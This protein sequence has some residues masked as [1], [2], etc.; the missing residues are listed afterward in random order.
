MWFHPGMTLPAEYGRWD[1]NDK[2]LVMREWVLSSLLTLLVG[3]GLFAPSAAG[4]AEIV[5]LDAFIQSLGYD[6]ATLDDLNGPGCGMNGI[7][8]ADEFAV[9]TT[10]L[11]DAGHPHHTAIH[12]AWQTNL[13]R[14]TS[15]LGPALLA[16]DPGLD[17]FLA[18]FAT[19]GSADDWMTIEYQLLFMYEPA[20]RPA[21]SNY[22]LSQ[23]SLLAQDG[24]LDGDGITNRDEY[25]VSDDRADYLLR[26]MDNAQSDAPGIWYVDKDTPAADGAQDGT[27]WATA[28]DTIQEG[29]DAAAAAYASTDDQAE[30]WVAEGT[31]DE[32]RTSDPHAG[33]T[34][35]GSL[36]LTAGVHLYGGFVGNGTGGNETA[37]GQRDWDAHPA[38]IDGSTARDGQPA[39]HVIMGADGATLDGF[40]VT[41][42]NANGASPMD[43]GAGIFNNH[44]SP[45]IANARFSEN[46]GTGDGGAVFNNGGA[47]TITHCTFTGNTTRWGACINSGPD[48]WPHVSYC[49][50]SG[51]TTTSLAGA[52]DSWDNT[53][54]T[55]IECTFTENSAPNGGGA[56]ST[57]DATVRLAGC[58]FLD[59]SSG[60]G[61]AIR[62]W[63]SGSLVN[64]TF[65]NNT[66]WGN[67][68]A[69]YVRGSASLLNCLFAHNAAEF[70]GVL[71][72]Y[73]SSDPIA[74]KNCTLANNAADGD[75]LAGAVS[76]YGSASR[77]VENSILW[78]NTAVAIQ[79]SSA[80]TVSYSDIQH[81]FSGESNL[82]IDPLFLGGPSGTCTGLS[83]DPATL[84]STLTDSGAAFTSGALA[85]AVL[86]LGDAGD[87]KAYLITANDA[88]QLTFWGDGTRSGALTAPVAYTV[89]DYRLDE[90]SLCIDT[91]TAD[92]APEDDLDGKARPQGSGI[93]RGAFEHDP[94]P[95]SDGD[96]I[97]DPVEGTA[98]P[99]GDSLPNYLDPDSDGDG[100]SD[101]TEGW[102]DHDG[103][104]T[105]DALDLDSDEDG[106]PDA[107]EGTGD[108]D[109]DGQPNYLDGDSDDDGWSDLTEH[110]EG[111]DPT[112]PE[113]YPGLPPG[114]SYH[115]NRMW[116]TLQQPWYFFTPAGIAID[117]QDMVYLAVRGDNKVIKFT[118]DGNVVAVWGTEGAGSGELYGPYA[119]AVDDEGGI[120]IRDG[121][122][123]GI[124]K[125]TPGGQYLSSLGADAGSGDLS[126][127][128]STRRST[129]MAPIPG[130]DTILVADDGHHTL[131]TFDL[132]GNFIAS[133]WG[134][135]GTDPYEF[136]YPT[137]V[138]YHAAAETYY[139]LDS[140]NFRVQKFSI[141]AVYQGEWGSEGTG[142]GQFLDPYCIAAS[143]LGYVYVADWN[144]AGYMARIIRFDLA[145][146]YLS[147]WGG[148][149][150]GPGESMEITG[151][152]V[153]S[154]GV[155]FVADKSE[156]QDGILLFSPEG[157]L[158]AEWT[159]TGTAPGRFNEPLGLAL[160]ADECVYVADVQ[161]HRIQKFTPEGQFL[162]AW[163]ELGTAPGQ[164][165]HPSGIDIDAAGNIYVADMFNDRVQKFDKDGAHLLT[166]G[167]SG[168]G[169]GEF[170]RARDVAVDDGDPDD[171]VV[172]VT[173]REN[174]RIQKFTDQGL[175]LEQWYMHTSSSASP[176][177][178]AVGPFGNVYVSSM[179]SDI[180]EKF[181][182]DGVF[183]GLLAGPGEAPGQV[184]SP[185]GLAFDS[186]GTLYVAEV[187]NHRIQRLTTDGL[188]LETWGGG[189]G[190]L[191]WPEGLVVDSTGAVHA[192]DNEYHRIQ[193]FVPLVIT[194]NS[195]AVI[196]A[197]LRDEG[198]SLWDDTRMC[199][200]YA[201][202]TLV[203]QGF[204]KDSIYY[205]SSDLLL[206]L[207]NNGV[208]DD[209][210][211]DA[212]SANLQTALETWGPAL[213]DGLP[214]SDVV[215]YL[216]DHGGPG[217]FWMAPTDVLDESSLSSWLDTL[218][219]GI[220]GTLTV[221]VDSCESGSLMD[222]L[223]APGRI[224]LTSTSPG[225]PAYFFTEGTIS[226]SNYFWTQIFN[227]LPIGEA[228]AA[229]RIAMDNYQ[230]ALLDDTGNGIPNEPGDG[231]VAATT[232][233][234][235]GTRQWW[236]G[237]AIGSVSA[238]QSIDGT[239]TAALWADPVTDADG[240]VRV[241]AVIRPPD[242]EDTS[243]S[244]AV[245]ALSSVD[246]M[247][248]GGNRYEATYNG[249]TTEGEYAVFI[250]ARD[251]TG[252]TS[253]PHATTVTVTNPLTRKVL[254]V[255][256][257][258]TVNGVTLDAR[259]PATEY[260]AGAAYNALKSQGYGD[261]DIQFLSHTTTPGVDGLAGLSNID[262]AINTWAASN[263]QDF[264][265][266]L[267]GYGEYG[268]F[269]VHDAE[270]LT[271]AQ[272][273]AWLDSLQ[274]T[275]P[276]K[277][278]VVNDTD[279][280]A[281][282]LPFLLPPAGKQ[283]IVIAGAQTSQ[284][285]Q[286]LLAG[287]ISFS[288]HFWSS[289][290]NG[291]TTLGAFW[292][293]AEAMAFAQT[294]EMDDN[295]DG[296]YDT[297]A[298]GTLA[299]SYL[300]GS[301]IVLAGSAPVIG[302]VAP[303]AT[304]SGSPTC[305]LWA[306][307]VTTAGSI[308]AVHAVIYP[309][310]HADT[311]TLLPQSTLPTLSLVLAGTG[312][313]RYEGA[314]DGF[315]AQGDYRVN[316]YAI[317]DEDN[318]SVP[319]S[320]TVHQTAGLGDGDTD[321]DGIPDNVEGP[322]DLDGDGQLNYA[323]LDSDGDSLLDAD[324]FHEDP[325]WDDLDGDGLLNCYDTDSDG[326]GLADDYETATGTDPYDP[327]DPPATPIHLKTIALMLLL[328]GS[329]LA[330]L[331]LRYAST[332]ARINP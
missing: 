107:D 246:L 93:D 325:D 196:V 7:L 30:V 283:R 56:V 2:G 210:D 226:F 258:R 136:N 33:G 48:A 297:K 117:A 267:V 252:N 273:D 214:T 292:R 280:A 293:A 36:M 97:N 242:Y 26:V 65:L 108:P 70:G 251:A 51:N 279:Q 41:G 301:G 231:I 134:V 232:H 87:E 129:Y 147:E 101:A 263:T 203:H 309:P 187:G 182:P 295:A 213:L 174:C 240:V 228:F 74:I 330:L 194:E 88:T 140:G 206:D 45:I 172:Y 47:V 49:T 120:Y 60:L 156:K 259:W 200:N 249:F 17:L 133:L 266:Y 132:D 154:E 128:T 318:P 227:G 62:I 212:T 113:D 34:N 331:R 66:A 225:E 313:R 262:W 46:S 191:F 141:D 222:G 76:F 150:S 3:F 61:G 42:G 285:A 254:I 243:S 180:V 218:Q 67:G 235:N 207:D 153:N 220:T 84:Q 131:K 178:I 261:A 290:A 238:P 302:S 13:A 43:S 16:T 78:G 4:D 24:D 98:D 324:E 99:D 77:T 21:Q 100:I 38:I 198:D 296:I 92:G 89:R 114:Q 192:S 257:A 282:F 96:G 300:L 170:N 308:H 234:G 173:D 1:G 245:V 105:Y 307:Q 216:C 22:D 15:D 175:W 195:K 233:I 18:A 321:G 277:V 260:N 208:A 188:S 223:A 201:Y 284:I 269:V 237:P 171:I 310:Y 189:V 40:G 116:P 135:Q 142:P 145:G 148:A 73:Y 162:D 270:Q 57:S 124:Q 186:E 281:T 167:V 165:D 123:A 164:F 75:S 168:T 5:D 111:T 53:T 94:V 287:R 119:I 299:I 211:A 69:I 298:D 72:D 305:T 268:A 152:A 127:P 320:M 183:L 90:T 55:L 52:I 265:L 125:F 176:E 184:D 86:L 109:G 144:D 81:G 63:G 115:F 12:T 68:G 157:G 149:G 319:V 322:G 37:R 304:L 244:N 130:A 143:P 314:W 10:I 253:E 274:A 185:R 219:A 329:T 294:A 14:M 138:A 332:Q 64:C 221:I 112:D 39:Y 323:D 122:H 250:Y 317:D 82:N 158:L 264:T 224:V 205:L 197:G 328:L 166:W 106:I 85:G 289:V 275:L 19:L 278:T 118:P 215:V 311:R 272:L 79:S 199:T 121:G 91:G 239:A 32:A 27:T 146:N 190:D 6:A 288:S 315:W 44:T 80:A 29:I 217:T 169:P 306:E 9:L 54:T 110:I 255:A 137:G 248:A 326:D 58:R 276:G 95:D 161:N 229:A 151:L 209:I 104:G 256:G 202:R 28:F 20:T 163:G 247:P 71:Y 159:A 11:A 155:V 303:D 312:D 25:R 230:T 35:T 8:D 59:N 102:T 181:T 286:F 160:N 236:Q 177:G 23:A 204:T 31:Y 193:K 83:Y 241:W 103:D 126:L 271:A 139:V 327:D 50:F 179:S 291:A 316:I